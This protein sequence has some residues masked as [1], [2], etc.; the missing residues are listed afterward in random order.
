VRTGRE[1][2]FGEEKRAYLRL[3]QENCGMVE[4]PA[5]RASVECGCVDPVCCGRRSM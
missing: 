2:I 5:L 4:A 3:E 1:T